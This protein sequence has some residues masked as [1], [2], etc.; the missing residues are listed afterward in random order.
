MTRSVIRNC[1]ESYEGFFDARRKY[2]ENIVTNKPPKFFLTNF[3]RKRV[4]LPF[5]VANLSKRERKRYHGEFILLYTTIALF[6]EKTKNKNK[7]PTLILL[8]ATSVYH[9]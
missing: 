2:L 8:F 3:Q 4:D 7:L 6:L 1:G 9:L 5:P